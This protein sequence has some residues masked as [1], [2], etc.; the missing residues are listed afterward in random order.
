VARAAGVWSGSLEELEAHL[1]EERPGSVRVQGL[2]NRRLS[3]DVAAY[4]L[5]E[6]GSAES[7][8]EA[9]RAE[10]QHVAPEGE[11]PQ[12]YWVLGESLGYAAHIHWADESAECFEVEYVR[13]DAAE[14]SVE[15]LPD[16]G[17]PAWE[18]GRPYAHEPVVQGLRQQLGSQLRE[19][20]L[21]ILPEYM[22]PAVFVT[23]DALPLTVNGKVDRRALPAP[24]GRLHIGG[25]E[26]PQGRIEE[27]LADIWREVL[28]VEEVGRGDNFFELGGHSLLG[29]KLIARIGRELDVLPPAATIFRFP[30]IHQMGEFVESL[31][32]ENVKPS[33]IMP[34]RETGLI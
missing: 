16:R 3:A 25:Y 20:L 26:A 4:R 31:L 23:L 22:V 34:E 21:G 33:T 5:I 8:V 27:A 17:W 6:S 19:H 24:E 9:L 14:E 29:M 18:A 28:R 7:T 12:A 32:S 15:G 30:T 13:V 1:R 11:D 10:L 2:R